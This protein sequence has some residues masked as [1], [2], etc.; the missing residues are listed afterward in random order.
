V[1]RPVA[2][3]P[4]PQ[5]A[6]PKDQRSTLLRL[7]PKGRRTYRRIVPQALDLEAALTSALA[8]GERK[9]LTA[10]LARLEACVAELE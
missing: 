1:A 4:L 2:A 9:A 7:A 6:N 10:T 3:G 5:G 8:P